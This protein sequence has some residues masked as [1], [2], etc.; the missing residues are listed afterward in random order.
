M[1]E[2]EE[3]QTETELEYEIENISND[4]RDSNI[5][6]DVSDSSTELRRS[7]RMPVVRDLGPFV[8]HEASIYDEPVS[9]KEAIKC[10]EWRESILMELRS[11]IENKTWIPIKNIPNGRKAIGY[12]FLFKNKYN[13]KY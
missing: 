2:E 11:H 1:S 10:R 6:N 12:K 4:I 5:S 7:R 9:L 8:A 13:E 3:S